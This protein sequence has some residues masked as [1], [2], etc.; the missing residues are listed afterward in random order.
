MAYVELHARSA[1]SFLRGA[2]LPE[3]LAATAARLE[4]P[5]LALCDRDG[6]A[7]AVRLYQKGREHGL[8][9]LVGSEMTM[10]DGV[11]VPLLVATQEGYRNLCGLLT[12]GNLR[13]PKGEGKVRWSELAEQNAGLIALTGD[14]AGPVRRA[15]RERSP[16]AAGEAL[17]RLRRVFGRDR[18][19][20][21][22]QRHL[23]PGEEFEN[24]FLADLAHAHGL[25]LLATNGALYASPS[26]RAVLDAFTCL[27]HHT[28][29]DAAGRRLARNGERGLQPAPAMA[30][31]FADWPEAIAQ[32]ERLAARLQF[33]LAD[34]GYRFPDYPVPA[35][36]TMDGFLH[37]MAYF[38]AQQRYGSVA[39][40]VRSQMERELRLIAKLGFSG[41]FLIVWDLCNFARGQG[42][43]VQGRGSAA[44]SV[45]CYALGITAVDPIE[46]QLLF[47]RFL[48]EGRT[49]WPD[50]DLDLPSEDRR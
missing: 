5:A 11:V 48:S 7:G 9:P 4:L 21:E 8:R 22:V 30:A 14:A 40:Q 43:L 29:L 33:T 27:R 41:Y 49:D 3:E 39:G 25:P 26:G 1:F 12:T 19:Y 50:I 38:G 46:S 18:L 20:V 47:E 44:N 37:K 34:L 45:V 2:S 15:W 10:E 28:T 31:R 32:T 36:E 23:T 16:A 35:G 13:A 17:A 42:T 24:Q 6:V